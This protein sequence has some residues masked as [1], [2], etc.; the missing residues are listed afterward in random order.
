M[1]P[2]PP[3]QPMQPIPPKKGMS[4]LMIALIVIGVIAVI[5]LGTCAVG[6]FF[7]QR[8]ATKMVADIN[9]GGMVLV[10]PPAVTAA[11]AGPKKDYV[12]A[13]KSK[14]KK[15]T[16]EIGAD[17]TVDSQKDEDGDGTKE[18]VNVPISQFIGDD[19]EV[20]P[21]ITIRFHVT[22]PPHAVGSG[23]EMVVDGVTYERK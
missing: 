22:T 7:V 1:Q 12:G 9:D 23:F 21:F 13:W 6:V 10:S 5:G 8:E 14:S 4:G 15:S 19:F 20:K 16:L 17:G 2:Y 3:Q 11:L 18:S